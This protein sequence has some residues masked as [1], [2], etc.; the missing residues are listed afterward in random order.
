MKHKYIL[1]IAL[2]LLTACA[3]N[4][5]E[6]SSSTKSSSAS[7]SSVSASPS[8][9]TISPNETV[10]ISG[11]GGTE[12]Y[13]FSMYSGDG[14]V[15]Q[16]TGTFQA[17]DQTGSSIVT[18]TDA[19]GNV[20]Y[21][22]IEI[23]SN[24]H[25]S[26]ASKSL[27]SGQTVSFYTNDGVEPY[28][29]QIISGGGSMNGNIY[30]APSYATS[31]TIEVSDAAGNTAQAYVTVNASTGLSISPKSVTI[32]AEESYDFTASGGSEPYSFSVVSGDGSFYGNI[33][34]AGSSVGT[35]KVKVTDAVGRTSTATVTVK[36]S[37]E[38]DRISTSAQAMADY[39]IGISWDNLT[40]SQPTL[41]FIGM[42]SSLKA[43]EIAKN[44]GSNCISGGVVGSPC[45]FH[46]A[47]GNLTNEDTYD[48][49]YK[50]TVTMQGRSATAQAEICVKPAE[51]N[52]AYI[53]W[54]SGARTNASINFNYSG[55]KFLST[56]T[57]KADYVAV[58]SNS[59]VGA[60]NISI[61]DAGYRSDSMCGTG[62]SS[63]EYI[64]VQ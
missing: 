5:K 33:F 12:P 56:R 6:E 42:G 19:N 21:S 35:T 24:I 4:N 32:Y 44:Y 45:A 18:V 46:V 2:T 61:S 7:S 36:L 50:A 41:V 64:Q 28:S 3:A 48:G 49:V 17:Y 57:I 58:D 43:S 27:N 62:F 9:I 34:I 13:K 51:K 16:N 31:A 11:S 47:L 63:L 23:S 37:E 10:T 30:T 38:E 39:N 22:Y 54:I 15:G 8:S 14:Y 40:Y 55:R 53:R 59:G 26:P 1:S 60:V 25:I 52:R 20:A 29:Y